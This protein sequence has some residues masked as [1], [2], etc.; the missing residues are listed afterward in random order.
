MEPSVVGVGGQQSILIQDE[1]G[2]VIFN[3][4]AQEFLIHAV[5]DYVARGA[6]L[7]SLRLSNK[8]MTTANTTAIW[9]E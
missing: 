8:N 2:V 9:C 6:V 5:P 1:V 7:F 3:Q 4:C